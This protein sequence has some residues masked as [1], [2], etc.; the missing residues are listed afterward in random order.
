[1]KAIDSSR[2]DVHARLAASGKW[3]QNAPRVPQL[4]GTSVMIAF[5]PVDA[6]VAMAMA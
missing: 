2:A 6:L 4:I 3:R 1:V 5:V